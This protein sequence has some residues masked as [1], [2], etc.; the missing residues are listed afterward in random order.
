MNWPG[1][2]ELR[3]AKVKLRLER[4]MGLGQAKQRAACSGDWAVL[5]AEEPHKGPEGERAQCIK[6]TESSSLQGE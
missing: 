1:L 2:E 6:G 5:E 3:E 4:G